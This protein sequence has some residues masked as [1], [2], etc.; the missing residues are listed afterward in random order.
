MK[1]KPPTSMFLRDKKQYCAG[2]AILVEFSFLSVTTLEFISI[3]ATSYITFN[4]KK[5]R[6]AFYE[7]DYCQMFLVDLKNDIC[8]I[9]FMNSHKNR[10][11]FFELNRNFLLLFSDFSMCQGRQGKNTSKN[12]SF[13]G[14]AFRLLTSIL[15]HSCSKFTLLRKPIF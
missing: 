10:Q 5:I 4:E 13:L 9:Q 1:K 15:A 7:N 11:Q 3:F 12:F 6:I 2:F 8:R 14:E